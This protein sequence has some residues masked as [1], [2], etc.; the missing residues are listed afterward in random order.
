MDKMLKATVALVGRERSLYVALRHLGQ[1]KKREMAEKELATVSRLLETSPRVEQARM[2]VDA[3]ER[4]VEKIAQDTV[5]KLNQ[6]QNFNETALKEQIG[7]ALTRTS[8]IPA[9][10]MSE[11]ENMSD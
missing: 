4:E 5:A 6:M 9:K 2:L 7:E 11:S 1:G 8:E 10:V 3:M